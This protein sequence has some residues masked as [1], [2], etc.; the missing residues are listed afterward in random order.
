MR[1]PKILQKGVSLI[2]VLITLIVLG[3][4]LMSLSKFQATVPK[5]NST[6]KE[7]TVA[8]HLAEQKMED[9]RNFSRLA[10]PNPQTVPPSASY[11]AIVTSTATA[12]GGRLDAAG[13]LVLP[14]GTVSSAELSN[15]NVQYTRS[16]RMQGWYYGNGAASVNAAATVTP[17]TPA[18]TYPP[19]KQVVVTVKWP[20]KSGT[21]PADCGLPTDVAQPASADTRVCLISFISSASPEPP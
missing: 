18:P 2:E 15:S 3:M 6:G 5:D 17:P 16:W 9:L 7:R 20:D 19:V 13:S 1:N 12:G 4:G 14:S 21:L 10:T 11:Q 8:V